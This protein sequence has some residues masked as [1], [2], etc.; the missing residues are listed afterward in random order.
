[1]GR[2]ADT[3]AGYTSATAHKVATATK[4]AAAKATATKMPTAKVPTAAKVTTTTTTKVATTTMSTAAAAVSAAAASEGLCLDRA[5]SEGDNRK[6]NSDL[7]Q[8]HTL[9][10]GRNGVLVSLSNGVLVSLSIAGILLLRERSGRIRHV[11]GEPLDVAFTRC[12]CG[13]FIVAPF[14]LGQ[15]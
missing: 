8:H 2:I 13:R 1:V 14:A 10:P 6:D 12:C 3:P 11:V 15:H 5:H 7:P 4:L 9:H